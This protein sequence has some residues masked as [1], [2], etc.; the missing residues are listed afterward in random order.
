M[1]ASSDTKNRWATRLDFNPNKH[2]APC[3]KQGTMEAETY[4]GSLPPYNITLGR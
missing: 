4:A 1:K 3:C 2:K